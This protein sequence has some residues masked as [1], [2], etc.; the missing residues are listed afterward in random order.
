MSK[1]HQV[2]YPNVSKNCP[3]TFEIGYTNSKNIMFSLAP[4]VDAK[5][6]WV[7][8]ELELDEEKTKKLNGSAIMCN[9]TDEVDAWV[10]KGCK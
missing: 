8:K 6:E 3:K 5:E 10:T 9:W 1:I 7:Q 2:V 4:L